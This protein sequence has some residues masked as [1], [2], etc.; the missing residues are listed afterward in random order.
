VRRVRIKS[1]EK[2]PIKGGTPAIENKRIVMVI[3][4]KLLKLKLLKECRV[5]NCVKTVLKRTQNK[6]T[7]EVLYINM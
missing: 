2:N 5:L 1:L 6:V 3:R 4:K 7:R